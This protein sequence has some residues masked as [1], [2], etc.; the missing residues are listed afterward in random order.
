MSSQ[1]RLIA[2]TAA[3]AACF[4]SFSASA[5]ED[6][7]TIRGIV[8]AV[9]R[10][11]MA[12]QNVPGVAV[13]IAINGKSYVFNYGVASKEE[14]IPVSDATMFEL[15]SISKPIA[16][17]LGSYAQVTGK[18]SL[19]DHPSK[20]MAQL[21]GTPIDKASLLNLATYTAGGLP[22]QFPDEV[23]DAQMVRYFQQWKPDAAPG[24]QRRY[25]NP[26]L[27][28]FGHLVALAMTDDYADLIKKHIFTPL[29]FTGS[30]IKVPPT[31]M[32]NYA[33]GYD[34]DN[35]A[36]RMKADVLSAPSGGVVSTASDMLRLVQANIDPSRLAAPMRR[37]I[38]GTH[39][40]Y[41][42]VG[43][44]VQGL[45]WEQYPYPLP[46]STLVAGNSS[47][48]NRA[49]NPAQ[50][51]AEPQR[52]RHTVLFSK[53][54]GTRGFNSYVAF[55]P[56]T[57]IGVVILANKSYEMKERITAGYEILGQLS[58]KTGH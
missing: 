17:T 6:S 5:T 20:Y 56:E 31:A 48:M 7:A 1:S 52:P 49:P 57:K 55:V 8:D 2:H 36:V 3:A 35:K 53:T 21:K 14:S 23:V 47:A 28:L 12:Q 37:A 22:L 58:L 32:G 41:F 54:G 16:A 40:G 29:G 50:Q 13:G 33:W 27:G 26:S 45:G 51:I 34:D 24:L 38:E 15:G 25:S 30:Y 9:I 18:L 46:L 11:L 19:N 43:P 44:M 39:V 4:L 42:K 10:P